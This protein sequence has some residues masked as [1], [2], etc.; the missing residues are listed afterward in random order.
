MTLTQLSGIVRFKVA[1]Q[2]A[3]P[4][5]MQTAL[6]DAL[7]NADSPPESLRFQCRIATDARENLSMIELAD[8]ETLTLH[9]QAR[10]QFGKNR[11]GHAYLTATM[12]Y[13]GDGQSYSIR[14]I[15]DGVP[16]KMQEI[17]VKHDKG[18]S[19]KPAT[20]IL[21]LANAQVTPSAVAHGNQNRTPEKAREDQRQ[22]RAK[23]KVEGVKKSRGKRNCA[24]LTDTDI[25]A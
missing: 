25:P 23:W 12:T 4:K 10:P 18:L 17:A 13:S 11:S 5:W 9:P 14:W 20:V 16:S 15:G 8:G 7:D 6:K 21:N 1:G 22:L 3:L 19:V 2:S 24:R